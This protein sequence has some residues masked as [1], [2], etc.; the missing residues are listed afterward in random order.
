[1]SEKK[2]PQAPAVKPRDNRG[3]VTQDSS[4]LIGN[5]RLPSFN[6][7]I[8]RHDSFV[9]QS[10]PRR[11]IGGGGGNGSGGNNGGSSNNR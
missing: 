1:M 11:P 7:E 3:T 5:T 6:E 9:M 10:Q 4:R 8:K 2:T